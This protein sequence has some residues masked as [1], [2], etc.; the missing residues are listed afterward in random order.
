M[1]CT[2]GTPRGAYPPR[3]PATEVEY[4]GRSTGE[5]PA[6]VEHAQLGLDRGGDVLGSELRPLC[7]V[8]AAI[9]DS[10]EPAGHDVEE[11]S[12]PGEQ[13]HRGEGELNRVGDVVEVHGVGNVTG[14]GCGRQECRRRRPNRPPVS[15]R[16]RPRSDESRQRLRSR[17]HA[18]EHRL[19]QFAGERV[20]LARVIGREQGASIG[21]RGLGQVREARAGR[22]ASLARLDLARTDDPPHL[23]ER[24]RA[25]RHEDANSAERFHLFF[26]PS[27]AS[28]LFERCRL[29]RR[30]CTADGG[31]DEH[32]V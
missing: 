23:V 31:G 20:L 29:V 22:S 2:R 1:A 3:S 11:A 4:C 26:E 6:P 5:V 32:R 24:E 9:N 28:C 14:P 30:R 19:G 12:D 27:T 17:P 10:R 13:K 16:R 21:K 8:T 15:T 18:V 7:D 25:E